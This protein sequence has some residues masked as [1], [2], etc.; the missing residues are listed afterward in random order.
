MFAAEEY[1]EFMSCAVSPCDQ[2]REVWGEWGQWNKC[3]RNCGGGL[4]LRYQYIVYCYKI[5][6]FLIL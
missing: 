5:K 1:A 4:A 3:S 2:Q 6:L